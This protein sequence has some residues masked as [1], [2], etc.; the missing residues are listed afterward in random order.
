MVH[1]KPCYAYHTEPSGAELSIWEAMRGVPSCVRGRGRKWMQRAPNPPPGK[2]HLCMPVAH[3]LGFLCQLHRKQS[4]TPVSYHTDFLPFPFCS[5]ALG[6]VET[7][8]CQRAISVKLFKP[9]RSLSW[10]HHG[11]ANECCTN[12]LNFINLNQTGWMTKKTIVQRNIQVI[13]ISS[14]LNILITFLYES[15]LKVKGVY[16]GSG[17]M[18]PPSYVVIRLVVCWQTDRWWQVKTYPPPLTLKQKLSET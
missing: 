5:R 3:P 6:W 10:V 4:M 17:T 1:R 8:R 9:P 15:T 18:P 16:S 2:L 13:E 11:K 7:S 12:L 14:W